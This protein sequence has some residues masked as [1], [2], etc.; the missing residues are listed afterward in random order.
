MAVQTGC[1]TSDRCRLAR[2]GSSR[3]CTRRA[4]KGEIRFLAGDR[5]TVNYYLIKARSS[6]SP[7]THYPILVPMSEAMSRKYPS[8]VVTASLAS[9]SLISAMS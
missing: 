8:A 5:S 4:I 3:R 1:R 7:R 9:V 2:Y 6:E